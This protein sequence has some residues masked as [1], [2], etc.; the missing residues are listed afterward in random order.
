[1]SILDR[2]LGRPLASSEEEEQK[3]GALAGVPM[4]GLDALSSA[5]YGPEAALTL[6]LPLGALGLAY[7]GPITTVILVLLVILYFSYRQTIVAYPNGGGSYTVAKENLGTRAG[8]LAAA[9]LMLD[10]IL[11]V[12]VGIAAGVGALVSAVPA[13]HGHVLALCLLI[14][15]ILTLVNLRGIRES[16]AAFILPTYLFVGCLGLT[17]IIGLAKALMSHGQPL[18]VEAPP[19]VPAATA[20][21]TLWLLMRSFASGCTAMTGVEAISNGISAFARPAVRNAQRTLTLIVLILGLL[22]AGIAYLCRAYHVAATDPDG[23]GYQSVLSMLVAAVM[24]RGFFYYVTLGSVLTVL[25]LSANT[26][27]AGFPR[28]CR[29]IAQDNFLPYAFAHRGRRLVYSLGIT[30]LTLLSALLLIAFGGITDRLIPLFAVGAFGAFTLSQAGMVRHWRH[31]PDTP[32]ARTSQVINAVGAAATGLALA[33]VLVAKF[34]DGA[35]ITLLLIPSLLLFFESVKR[36]YAHVA[37]QIRCPRPLNL[38][39]LAPPV[40]VV[41]VRQWSTVVENAMRV[42]LTLSPDVIAVHVGADEEEADHLRKRW[43][44]HVEEPIRRSGLAQPRLRIIPSPY[45]HLLNPLSEA[46]GQ[47]K[48]EYPTRL[49]A[50]IIPELVGSHWYEYLLHNQRSTWLKAALL[51]RG[52]QRVVVI[53]VPWYLDRQ[54]A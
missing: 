9:S 11:N 1:M 33:V 14:L 18:P 4:L 47:I 3:V 7:I 31:H 34:R 40:V 53:N 51:M 12:A 25:A 44:E 23:A 45:R 21:L 8:L 41:P 50:V 10:Y 38:T 35:W 17:L 16:G 49:I 6:L 26:S 52:D 20:G 30:I 29:L 42:A 46:I 39:H 43:A 54:N 24:G 36:H 37:Q 15:A 32:G 27:F 48:N 22:L 2:M 5:A 28:L 19:A 13:L